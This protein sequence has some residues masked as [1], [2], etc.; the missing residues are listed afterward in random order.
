MST[1]TK[2]LIKHFT[3]Y[4]L[5]VSLFFSMIILITNILEN[6]EYFSGFGF[7]IPYIIFLSL[8]NTPSTVYDIFP[9]IFLIT[10]QFFFISL[11]DKN[12]LGIFKYS[13]LAN[14]NIIKI[15]GIYTFILS[16][17]LVVIFYNISATLK[18]SYLVIK[19]NY[20]NDGKYL[21]VIT[22]NG[23][24]MKDTI[25]KN[26]NIIN[27][28]KI[29]NEF[30]SQVTISQFNQNFEPLRIITADKINVSSIEWEIFNATILEGNK[31]ANLDK[32]VFKSN[33]D[34][35]RINNL[36]SNLSSL[37]IIDLFELR[38]NYNLLNYSIIEIDSHLYRIVSYPIYLTLITIFSSIVM[39]NIK[40]RKNSLFKIIFGI[41]L[42]VVIFYINYFFNILGIS[43]KIPIIISIFLPL[44]ILM[45]INFIYI[46]KIN[47]K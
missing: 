33:F 18:Q 3:A 39:L 21:A 40:Y 4:F 12:E 15:I 42:A 8:L 46:V 28:N 26:I 7:N 41:L 44:S 47:E 5:K 34:L 24:W 16:I 11:I 22:Q 43:E 6:Y 2:F 20:S 1:Y 9:F 36:F 31:T 37:N 30:L 10:T 27:A 45:I 38:K 17:I 14:H 32:L 35:K 29:D 23:L 25:D 13:G 19:N